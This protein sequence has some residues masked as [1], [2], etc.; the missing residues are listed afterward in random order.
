[1]TDKASLDDV[2]TPRWHNGNESRFM[3][4]KDGWCMV[5]RKGAAPYLIG[6]KEWLALPDSET[7]R[8]YSNEFKKAVFSR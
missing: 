1:M 8:I 4:E 3:V 7:G 2:R 5:R 6:T